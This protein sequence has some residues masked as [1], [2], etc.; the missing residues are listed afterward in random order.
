VE[1]MND[2]RIITED[3]E[4]CV[5]GNMEEAF[6]LLA[7][8]GRQARVI[9]GGTDLLVGIKTGKVQP[10]CLINIRPIEGMERL[11]ESG[12]G[13]TVGAGCLFHQIESSYL[14]RERYTALYEAVRSI[15][16]TQI[17]NMGT[18]G[19]NICNGS[20][21]ADSAPALLVLGAGARV[22]RSGGE[23]VLPLDEFFVNPGE[24]ALSWDEI[25]KE[26]EIPFCGS[27]TGSAFLKI[28][29]VS[30]DLAKV[31]AA[32]VIKRN[33]DVCE[34]C[35]IA[36]GSVAKTPLRTK[37]AEI[38]MRGQRYQEG[39]TR[40]VAQKASEEISPI[41]DIRSTEEYRREVSK[42]IVR[43]ALERAWE[44]AGR[45]V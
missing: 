21:A 42:A 3:F 36:L 14:V 20:P 16:P 6:S 4:Y 29:R 31:N 41:T 24:T 45:R 25:L 13:L 40:A 15:G 19:G 9:A 43:D 5:A 33:R 12:N 8:H 28:G 30:A 18:I 38:L 17:K 26:I 10:D 11:H 34:E 7:K 32:V 1:E 35:R 27:G 44:R 37:G 22:V 23:R 2:S 39:L